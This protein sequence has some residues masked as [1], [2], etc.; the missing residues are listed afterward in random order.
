[1]DIFLGVDHRP[2]GM[3]SA[4][5]PPSEAHGYVSPL[6]S[7][8]HPPE[9]TA[10]PHQPLQSTTPAPSD[11][12]KAKPKNFLLEMRNQMPTST[13][14]FLRDFTIRCRGTASPGDSSVP[15]LIRAYVLAHPECPG[16]AEAYNSACEA[17][18]R[19]RERHMGLAH[20][21]IAVM[22]RLEGRAGGSG[23]VGTG[24]S[25]MMPFLKQAKAE[26]VERIVGLAPPRN[27]D[28]KPEDEFA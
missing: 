5:A 12:T 26:T 16:L 3:K 11:V 6:S 1:M 2:T 17:T 13:R 8:R 27:P 14:L 21:Y 19:F 4:A 20:S 22:A 24:G 25:E 28:E 10:Q 9:S 7:A 18:K 23:S 15:G